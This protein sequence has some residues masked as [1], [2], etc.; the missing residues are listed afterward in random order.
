M[1]NLVIK[2]ATKIHIPC[3]RWNKGV[4]EN[5]LEVEICTTIHTYMIPTGI[6]RPIL[7]IDRLLSSQLQNKLERLVVND[8]LAGGSVPSQACESSKT[9]LPSASPVVDTPQ[10]TQSN[11]AF[12]PSDTTI[13]PISLGTH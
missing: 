9:V 8:H 11:T 10:S 1:K 4:P 6:Y 7:T 13:T 2:L 3:E 12:N 5:S